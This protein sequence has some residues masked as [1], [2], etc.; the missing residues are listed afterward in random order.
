[1][2]GKEH[3]KRFLQDKSLSTA[4]YNHLH[5]YFHRNPKL[6]D[7]QSLAA[8]WLAKETFLEAWKE[9][10]IIAESKESEQKDAT[11]IGL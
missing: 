10:Q 3:F 8:A 5:E 7:V 9:L 1:M 2:P 11:N 6:K 4:V